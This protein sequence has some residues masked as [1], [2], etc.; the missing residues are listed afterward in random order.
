MDEIIAIL[1]EKMGSPDF[2]NKYLTEFEKSFLKTYQPEKM[3]IIYGSLAP[4]APNHH[5]VEYIK[6]IW[7]Q[8]IV[9]GKLM[10][11]GWGADLGY[12]AFKHAP[13]TEQTEIKAH[14]LISNEL[15]ANWDY[16]DNFEGSGYKRILAKF[17]LENGNIGIGF[18]YAINETFY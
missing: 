4:N 8:G 14:I 5:I 7:Q 17:E 1:N 3:L 11:Y 16:L 12:Y 18:I 6:G 9:K 13:I 2:Q 10:Q 15:T